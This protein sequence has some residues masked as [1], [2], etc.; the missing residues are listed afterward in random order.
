MAIRRK[1]AARLYYNNMDE[2]ET[3]AAITQHRIGF[4]IRACLSYCVAMR[5]TVLTKSGRWTNLKWEC[6]RRRYAMRVKPH[7][8]V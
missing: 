3:V 1:Q 7:S 4:D 8:I 6:L 2:M 5:R